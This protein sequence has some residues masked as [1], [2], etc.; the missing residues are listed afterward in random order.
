MYDKGNHSFR[1]SGAGWEVIGLLFNSYEFI[2]LFLPITFLLFFAG[3]KHGGSKTAT[4]WLTAAS[5]FFYGWWDYR[6]VPLLFGSICFNYFI[7]RRIEAAA[8]GKGWL[9]L[10]IAGNLLL[11][12]GFKYTGFFLETANSLA[13]RVMFNVPQIV[14]PLGISFF[15][16]TQSAYLVDIYRRETKNEGFLTYCEFVTIFPHLIAGPIISHKK[17]MPQFTDARNFVINWENLARGICLFTMGLF[18][19]VVR[20]ILS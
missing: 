4:F 6:Y 12:G 9:V 17:M 10:G 18:K 7:G 1:K 3:A 2:F 13:G 8:R 11:L 15:T 14:L 5:F 19:K 20:I 16:F